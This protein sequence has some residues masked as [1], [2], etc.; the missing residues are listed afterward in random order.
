M[1]TRS[2]DAGPFSAERRHSFG[3]A[4]RRARVEAGM[5]L[6]ALA[7]QVHFSKSHLSKVESGLVPPSAEFA[8]RV[9][10][11]LQAGGRL[12]DLVARPTDRSGSPFADDVASARLHAQAGGPVAHHALAHVDGAR[13][14]QTVQVFRVLLKNVRK[15]GQTLGPSVIMPILEPQTTALIQLASRPEPGAAEG[16]RL[17]S[18]FATFTGWMAQEMGNEDSA[19]RWTERAALLAE[20][21]GD[22]ELTAYAYVRRANIALYRGD[23]YATIA[24]AQKAR[25]MRCGPKVRKQALE[26][27]AQ[28]Q[29]L[30]GNYAAFRACI[31]DAKEMPVGPV[32]AG[33]SDEPVLGTMNIADTTAFAEGWS[34]HDLGRSAAAVNVLVPVF[35]DTAEDSVRAWARI[36]AR[37]ALAHAG[38]GDIDSACDVAERI[39][40]L[41]P[42]LESATIRFDLRLLARELNRWH[43]HPRIQLMMPRLSAALMPASTPMGPG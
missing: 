23:P 42:A 12:A 4:L 13:L 17:A 41:F 30:A 1:S 24:L 43:S 14:D 15:L 2:R 16:L 40:R 29:A 5:S 39:V 35:N 8:R 26:R 34:L 21:A 38:A 10:S 18:Q 9:D 33:H 7:E 28:G 36:G 22:D 25:T 27:E 37:L 31:E 20:S 19:L 11:A 6:T 3:A 32:A